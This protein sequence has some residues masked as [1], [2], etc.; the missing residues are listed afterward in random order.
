MTP[1]RA[2]KVSPRPP[3]VTGNSI[4]LW[5]AKKCQ[6]ICSPGC[7]SDVPDFLVGTHK[8]EVVDFYKYLGFRVVIFERTFINLTVVLEIV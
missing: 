3:K 4:E 2:P 7:P 8:L 5:E 6:I 1:S